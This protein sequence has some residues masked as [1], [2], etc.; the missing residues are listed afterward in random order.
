M[1]LVDRMKEREAD[2]R[3]LAKEIHRV[4]PMDNSIRQ[5]QLVQLLETCSKNGNLAFHSAMAA[6]VFVNQFLSA[7]KMTRG[8]MNAVKQKLIKKQEKM[9]RQETESRLLGLIQLWADT[10][11]MKE[12][13]FPGFQ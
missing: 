6:P 5:Q 11:M 3:Q 4:L 2:C 13:Q 1:E 12:D 10:F 9:R 7:L 8:K